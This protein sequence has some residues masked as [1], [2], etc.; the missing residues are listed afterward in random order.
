MTFETAVRATEI[1]LALAFVQQS[2]EHLK[3]STAIRWLFLLRILAC[4][5]LLSGLASIPELVTLALISLVMLHRFQGPY[6]GGSDR[7][8]LLI[9]W[10]L[11]LAQITPSPRWQIVA[12]AYLAAQLTL[13]YFISGW[14]KLLNPEWRSGRALRDVFQ[15]SAYP[16]SEHLRALSNR[17]TLCWT[18]SWAVILFELL[19][20]LSLLHQ[21]LLIAALGIAALFHLANACLFGLNRFFW[22]W[23]AAYPSLL[24][25]QWFIFEAT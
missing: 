21:N 8:S 18:M 13:S 10:C 4:L 16:V 19:L 25:F 22:I 20:P 9:L 1:L 3:T 12:F 14:V 2:L 17:P 24:W 11:L 15:F 7:M 5:A 23:L 6:N